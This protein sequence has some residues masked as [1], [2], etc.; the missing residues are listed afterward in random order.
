[1]RCES[2]ENNPR[3]I[4]KAVAIILLAHYVGDI[5]QPL[6]VG[7]EY[8]NDAG[9]AIDPDKTRAALADEGGNTLSLHL[10]TGT[11]EELAHHAL[12]V[13]GF[14]DNDAVME[15]LPSLPSTMPKEQRRDQIEAAKRELINQW[16]ATEPRNWRL[17]AS[18]ALK[19]YAE[20]WANEMLPLA[21][22]AHERLRFSKVHPQQQE[23]GPIVATGAAQ[24]ISAPDRVA[25]HEWAGRIVREELQRA[26]WRL[27]DLLEKTVP[28]TSTS[29]SPAHV[30]PTP[31]AAIRST[32]VQPVAPTITPIPHPPVTSAVAATPASPYGDYPA[33]Y[34]EVVIAWV[35]IKALDT[36]QIDWQ[37][38]PKPVELPGL[39]GEHL[40]GYLIVFNTRTR[41]NALMQTRSALIHDGRVI[42]TLRFDR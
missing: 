19:D 35:K 12:K 42:Y 38:E 29:V 1:V 11:Q 21:R 24:E 23:G 16:G 31:T 14:W 2:P 8:F 7:A 10:S 15:N 37:T 34:K 3:K 26:G 18:V 6:H 25:Y 13:H 9:Q 33:N 28:S 40:Y 17:P 32:I 30:S 41:S 20:N 5:H 4:T 27:A 39:S 22:Q 36:S